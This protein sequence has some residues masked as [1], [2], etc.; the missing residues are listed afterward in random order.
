MIKLSDYIVQQLAAE[1]VTGCDLFD[2]RLRRPAGIRGRRN[3]HHGP[4]VEGAVHRLETRNA[5]GRY[6][7]L[8]VAHQNV[9]CLTLRFP[10]RAQRPIATEPR[11]PARQ[12]R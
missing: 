3:R 7:R 6:Q 4:R 1:Q 12:R 2:D 11:W 8:G 5:G 9:E 10:R